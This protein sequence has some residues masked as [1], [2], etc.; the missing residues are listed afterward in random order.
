DPRSTRNLVHVVDGPRPQPIQYLHRRCR[1]AAPN[2][3][4]T[5]SPASL[6]RYLSFLRNEGRLHEDLRRSAMQT[7]DGRRA[8]RVLRAAQR[9]SVVIR[10]LPRVSNTSIC[11]HPIIG[12]HVLTNCYRH[13]TWLH[14]KLGLCKW[15]IRLFARGVLF[16]PKVAREVEHVRQRRSFCR[17]T[18]YHSFAHFY[19]SRTACI[20]CLARLSKRALL[21]D[22]QL[23]STAGCKRLRCLAGWPCPSSPH[24]ELAPPHRGTRV[25]QMRRIA[26]DAY[27]RLSPT[28]LRA[29]EHAAALRRPPALVSRT[30]RCLHLRG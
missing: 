21:L 18:R 26:P 15:R 11:K 29:S 23:A 5:V 20:P 22:L 27:A 4:L 24:F 13:S 19:E 8:Q 1:Q 17:V 9:E 12:A 14:A 10:Q 16:D 28:L 30:P 2:D 25:S 7:V 6:R 3:Y